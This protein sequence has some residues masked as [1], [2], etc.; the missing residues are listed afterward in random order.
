MKMKDH[1]KFPDQKFPLYMM[2]SIDEDVEKSSLTDQDDVGSGVSARYASTSHAKRVTSSR[3]SI[4]GDHRRSR[5]DSP[6]Y[7]RREVRVVSRRY[8][9]DDR[10]YRDRSEPSPHPGRGYRHLMTT[11]F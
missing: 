1:L 2:A 9:S 7:D 6:E 8:I 4:S 5:R 10:D 3:S 11:S